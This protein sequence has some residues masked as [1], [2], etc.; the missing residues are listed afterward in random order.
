MKITKQ[1]V[2]YSTELDKYC[3][4]ANSGDLMEVRPWI[5]GGGYTILLEKE[6]CND[7]SFIDLTVGE[8]RLLKKMIKK[9]NQ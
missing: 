2:A 8:F 5:N 9:L 4:F 6:K 3:S 7:V 1:H